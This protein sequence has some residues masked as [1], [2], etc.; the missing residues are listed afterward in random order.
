MT[1]SA[2]LP[3]KVVSIVFSVCNL[4]SFPTK[5]RKRSYHII[6]TTTTTYLVTIIV[7]VVVVL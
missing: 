6:I 7:V 2:P 5:K 3:W 1:L 4:P